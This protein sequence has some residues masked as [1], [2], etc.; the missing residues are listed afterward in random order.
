MRGWECLR[1]YGDCLGG[2]WQRIG[3]ARGGPFASRWHYGLKHP[4]T[5]SW[6]A[7]VSGCCW[8]PR[9]PGGADGA[10]GDKTLLLESILFYISLGSEV[11][12]CSVIPETRCPTEIWV[13]LAGENCGFFSMVF[14]R[15]HSA[16][17]EGSVLGWVGRRKPE[18]KAGSSG[19]KL[20]VSLS[21]PLF[22]FCGLFFFL[23]I[24]LYFIFV[25][26]FF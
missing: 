3:G 1:R 12:G 10:F 11:A 14:G 26:F 16:A 9:V 17:V 18:K 20:N 21:I 6:V 2:L 7:P 25:G 5:R 23:F 8:V 19:V 15:P 22:Y 4:H 13:D 24:N